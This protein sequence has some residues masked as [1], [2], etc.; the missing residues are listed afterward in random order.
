[1]YEPPQRDDRIAGVKYRPSTNERGGMNDVF[2]S[3]SDYPTVKIESR[4]GAAA[5]E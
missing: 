3:Q 2:N 5:A 1:L 4:R